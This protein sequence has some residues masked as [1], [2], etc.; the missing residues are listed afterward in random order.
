[1]SMGLV[2]SQEARQNLLAILEF[3]NRDSPARALSYI[4]KIRSR[5]EKLKRFPL[6]GRVVPELRDEPGP[7][8]EIIIDA[9]RV[10]YRIQRHNV[11]V[12]T[13]F[14]GRRIIPADLL[15]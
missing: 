13:V 4:A 10:I 7:P 2:W 5:V 15:A 1:M 6:V 11:E 9:Y 12:I 8:R 3:I 14:H